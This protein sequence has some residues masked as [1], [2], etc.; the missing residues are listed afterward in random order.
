MPA[1]RGQKDLSLAH[2]LVAV[3]PNER[4]PGNPGAI[5]IARSLRGATDRERAL[6]GRRREP[7]GQVAELRQEQT[8]LNHLT[9]ADRISEQQPRSA[10]LDSAENG[11][12]G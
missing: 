12:S 9:K 10:G 8:C 1:E 4:D 7:D 2:P 11:T 3:L 6:L 5:Q